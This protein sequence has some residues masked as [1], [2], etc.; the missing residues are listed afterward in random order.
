[1]KITSIIAAT[2][3]LSAIAGAAYAGEWA[4]RCVERLKADG[5]DTSGCSCLE[6][7]INADPSLADEFTKLAEIADPAARYAA[8]SA[9]A[10]AAM[11]AC[12]R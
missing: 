7:R 2:A 10:K 8:A 11:D 1:M 5:R 12:T 3:A 4:D 6:E 9:S